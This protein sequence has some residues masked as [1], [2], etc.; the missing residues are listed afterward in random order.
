M[1]TPADVSCP[2]ESELVRLATGD[3]IPPEMGDR[4]ERHLESCPAC[5]EAVRRL[6]SEI[7][8]V[9]GLPSLATGLVAPAGSPPP[10]P[11]RQEVHWG[12]QRPREPLGGPD[13]QRDP[14]DARPGGRPGWERP[15][16]LGA[17]PLDRV[18]E[19]GRPVEPGLPRSGEAPADDQGAVSP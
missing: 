18:P 1:M 12:L 6:R 14:P 7:L 13:G 5:R 4:L 16:Q 9:R 10:D 11:R 19:E 8:E 3:P 17:R 2:A 15:G